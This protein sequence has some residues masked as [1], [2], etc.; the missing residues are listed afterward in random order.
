MSCATTC[1]YCKEWENVSSVNALLTWKHPICAGM[2]VGAVAAYLF[3]FSYLEYTYLTFACR[4]VQLVL[5]TKFVKS[6]FGSSSAECCDSE[7]CVEK[8]ETSLTEKVKKY[9]PTLVSTCKCMHSIATWEDKSKTGQFFAASL[10]LACI[11]NW[12][13]FTQL[14]VIATVGCFTLPLGYEKNQA[15]VDAQI[16]NLKPMVNQMLA[17]I[18]AISSQKKNE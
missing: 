16:E 10:V 9:V 12:F 4:M 1:K 6:F 3:L 2:V 18:P 15:L 7:E 13:S 14:V 5:I 11:G 8:L 17:K